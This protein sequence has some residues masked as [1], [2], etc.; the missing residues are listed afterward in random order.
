MAVGYGTLILSDISIFSQSLNLL[1][2]LAALMVG[3]I[4]VSIINDITD[5]DEDSAAG[6]T[7]RIAK[8]PAKYRWML[9]VFCVLIGI[10]FSLAFYKDALTTILYLMAW[11]SFSLYSLPPIRLKKRG[12]WGLLADASG[13]HLFTS[14]FIVSGISYFAN[15]EIDWIWFSAIGCWSITYGLRGI[16]WHQFSDR[17]NDIRSGI[18]TFATK[19]NPSQFKIA[20]WV[21]TSLELAAFFVMLISVF[22]IIP[23]IFVVIYLIMMWDRKRKF[24]MEIITIISP[25]DKP[26]QILMSEY[27]QVFFPLALLIS[28]A[29]NYPNTWLIFVFHFILFPKN[30]VLVITHIVELLRQQ[31]L[32]KH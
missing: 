9:P 8:I 5:I 31:F 30:T 14:L 12:W 26:Y 32:I 18:N 16:L 4:Y 7:N 28:G 2:L 1:L 10:A 24:K 27:Y 21:L 17:L 22:K 20:S 3:A 29:L 19:I 25:A 6:K 23:I 13:A 11:I 15:K